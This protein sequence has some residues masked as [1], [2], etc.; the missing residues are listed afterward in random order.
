MVRDV[1]LAAAVGLTLLVDAFVAEPN[2]HLTRAPDAGAVAL[3]L[4]IAASLVA[5][6]RRPVAV[7]AVVWVLTLA[8]LLARYPQGPLWLGLI[9]AFYT[10]IVTGHRLAGAVA[11]LSGYLAFPW[12]DKILGRGGAPSP[13]LVSSLAVLLLAAFGLGES[14]RVR[15][16]RAAQAVRIRAEEAT[17][18]ASEER[19]RIAQEIHDVVAHNISL[20]NVQASVALD[21]NEQLPEQART[22]L[23][24]IKQASRE[25]LGGLR[26]VLDVLRQPG[27]LAAPLT[28]VPGLAQVQDLVE[29]AKRVGLD[30]R[31][32]VEGTPVALTA[33]VDLAAYRI[34]Q[35]SLTN[36]IRHARAAAVWVRVAYGPDELRIRVEDDGSGP[37]A[38]REG[39][40]GNG[41]PGMRER[42]AAL[43]GKLEA[44]L[45]PGGGFQVLAWLPVEPPAE[46]PR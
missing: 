8:Y 6:R 45:R 34:V 44:G 19:L 9:I 40:G 2:P 11:G 7:L 22:A 39:S 46:P 3:I 30:A 42:A 29:G 24:A 1:A 17:R 26:T 10:S 32:E 38:Q 33:P 28:P 35:E 5:R 43:G 14:V 4:A 23:T 21:V 18:Q 27:D 16:Q 25:A 15:R 37:Q 36:V 12:L 41:I 13:S 20:V 31:L